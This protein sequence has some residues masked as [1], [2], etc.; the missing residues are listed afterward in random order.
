LEALKNDLALEL[1]RQIPVRTPQADAQSTEES[2]PGALKTHTFRV[3]YQ[4]D[5]EVW[6]EIEISEEQTLHQL[7]RAIQESVG[8]D[9]DH[10]YS[11]YMSGRAGDKRT[12]YF[13]MQGA[14]PST[15]RAVIGDLQ[16]RMKQTFL[17]LFDFGDDHRFDFQLITVNP[18]ASKDM[19]Y[20][21]IVKTHGESPRQYHWEDEDWEDDD[22]DWD[23]D[24]ED[25]GDDD[26]DF[27][28]I[29]K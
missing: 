7:H 8:F 16:L 4:R 22:E 12:E 26:V 18:D 2:A 6:R 19:E 9:S 21:Q 14:R 15:T 25:W 28:D 13:S 5:T 29:F 3:T 17:Y 1:A 10:L 20:P 27:E 24:D 23:D 11:F